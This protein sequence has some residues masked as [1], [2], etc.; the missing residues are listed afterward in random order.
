MRCDEAR[1]RLEAAFD[2][3]LEASERVRV[4]AHREEC[5][6]CAKAWEDLH[7]VRRLVR[8]A[9]PPPSALWERIE[10]SLGTQRRRVAPPRSWWVP[11]VAAASIGAVLLLGAAASW[12]KSVEPGG[13]AEAPGLAPELDELRRAVTGT[14]AWLG[15]GPGLPITPEER[16]LQRV[17]G[18]TSSQRAQGGGR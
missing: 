10:S 13:S 3:A 6:G 2:G 4:D 17:L 9:P 14:S 1:G 8:A 16:V 12:A 11:R 5:L 7:A 18:G 15:S